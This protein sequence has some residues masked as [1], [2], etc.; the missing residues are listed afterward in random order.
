MNIQVV[1]LSFLLGL[2]ATKLQKVLL[3]YMS[4]LTTFSNAMCIHVLVHFLLLLMDYYE[5]T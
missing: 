4:I 5:I 1:I 3:Y 2:I